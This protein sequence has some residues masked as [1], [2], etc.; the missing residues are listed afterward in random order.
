M[1]RDGRG[2]L[3]KKPVSAN[4]GSILIYVLWILVVISALAFHLAAT[5]RATT[6]NQSAFANQLKLQMQ[7]NSAIQFSIYKIISNQWKDKDFE[8]DLNNQHIDISVFNEAGYV[9]IYNLEDKTL[10]RIFESVNLEESTIEALDE[11]FT[12][13][14]NPLRFNSFVEL[15]RFEGIDTEM[16]NLLA[17]LVS[18]LHEEAVNPMSAPVEVLM[19]IPGIDQF[20]VQKL[21]EAVDELEKSEL[22][23]ELTNLLSRLDMTF[24][25]NP[26]AYF[27]VNISID[28]VLNRVFVIYNRQQK[29]YKVVLVD[30]AVKP[31]VESTF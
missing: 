31:V 26:S 6:L 29:K 13:E 16:V 5:S 28:G 11:A 30:R 10:K 3:R 4:A 2:C 8:L 21:K 22:R 7:L 14:E 19:K 1:N 18:L 25:E 24:S 27:R 17:P 15:Q 20:R 23:K 9:S 12:R